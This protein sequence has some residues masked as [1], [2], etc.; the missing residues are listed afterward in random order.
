MSIYSLAAKIH[1]AWSEPYYRRRLVWF[2][3]IFIA[4]ACFRVLTFGVWDSERVLS[5]IKSQEI[6]SYRS[7]VY[8]RYGLM[9]KEFAEEPLPAGEALDEIQDM[10]VELSNVSMSAS[11]FS[12]SAQDTV[13]VRYSYRLSAGGEVRRNEE[14]K[15]VKVTRK[16]GYHS[17]NSFAL[18]YYLNY[19]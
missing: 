19:L 6:E 15:Y 7:A 9:G 1:Q 4:F 10:R 14:G 11:L 13:V 3:A 2:F 8:K 17:W 16:G 12:F 5:F 18:D